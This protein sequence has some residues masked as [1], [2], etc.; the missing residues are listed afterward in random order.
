LAKMK[1]DPIFAQNK[2]YKIVSHVEDVL[3]FEYEN[4]ERIVVG[5]LNVGNV[6]GVMNVSLPDGSYPHLITSKPI[7]INHG[8]I[9]LSDRPILFQVPK[10]RK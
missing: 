7:H 1:K 5:I 2:G 9:A 8:S 3:H 6:S 4:D 10:E